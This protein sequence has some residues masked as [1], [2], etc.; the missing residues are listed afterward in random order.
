MRKIL[1]AAMVAL[2]LGLA[3]M[4]GAS[5]ANIGTGV[6]SAA[7]NASLVEQIQYYYGHRRYYGHR[8]YCRNVRVCR[9]THGYN[10]C[11]WV[12]VCR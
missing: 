5:A 12:R 6:D 9:Y 11:R 10:R 8:S 3:G 1:T 7:K 2:G 4:T